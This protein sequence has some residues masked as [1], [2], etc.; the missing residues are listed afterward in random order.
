M[1]D[2]ANDSSQ[3][4]ASSFSAP[5]I[6]PESENNKTRLSDLEVS[7]PGVATSVDCPQS[8][9]AMGR[10]VLTAFHARGG[11]GEVWRCQ[12]SN[13]GR[14][15]ALKRLVG[16]HASAKERFLCEA[17]IAG[18]L[19]HPSIVPVHDLGV[20]DNGRPFYVMKFVRGR[21][22]KAAIEDF[23]A[24]V[25]PAI[26][27]HEARQIARLR[28]LKIFLDL[29]H[30]V[31]YAHSR[32]VIH[33]DIKPEIVMVGPYGETV[34]LDWGLAKLTGQTEIAALTPVSGSSCDQPALSSGNS[35]QTQDGSILGSPLYMPP[36]MA[37]GRMGDIDQRTDVYLLGATLYEILTGRPPRQGASRQEILEMART[38]PPVSPRTLASDTPRALEAICLKAMSRARERRYDGAMSVAEEIQRFLAGESVL[39]YAEPWPVRAWR[40][41]KRHR[42]PMTRAIV[43]AAFIVAVALVLI[44]YM[45]SAAGAA[46]EQARVQV[47]Q[48]RKLADQARFY[49]AGVDAPTEL[50]PYYNPGHGED[51]ARE[52][53]ATAGGWGP[54][55]D[56][57]PLV[58][59]RQPLRQELGE[60]CLLMAGNRAEPTDSRTQRTGQSNTWIDHAK[61]LGVD[62]PGSASS[63]QS[64]FLEAER[65]RLRA[66]VGA[67]PVLEDPDAKRNRTE[68]LLNA[69]E[70][71]QAA[72]V[73][74]PTLYWPHLQLGRCYLAL[75]RGPQAIE[76]LGACIALRPDAPWGYSVRGLALALMGRFDA[77]KLD[78]D[79][80]LALDPDCLAARLNRGGMYQLEGMTEQAA[81]EFDMLLALPRPSPEAAM[82]RSRIYTDESKYDQALICLDRA[83][84][85]PAQFP[86]AAYLTAKL[87]F[88]SG[89]SDRCLHQLDI[90]AGTPAQRG[91]LLRVMASELPRQQQK[92]LLELALQDLRPATESPGAPAG[93]LADL[94]AVL[95]LLDRHEEAIAAYSRAIAAAPDQAQIIIN[96]GWAFDSLNRLDEARNDFTRALQV[97]PDQAEAM[98]GLGYV[99]ARLGHAAEA[100]RQASLAVLQGGSE[101]LILHNVACIYAQL[102][103]ADPESAPAHQEAAVELLRRSIQEWRQGWYGQSEIDL[104]RQ[105]PA[106]PASMRQRK[107]FQKLIGTPQDSFSA[108]RQHV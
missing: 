106:F 31:A 90:I 8:A 68:S 12:D 20:D 97:A 93:A 52:A 96:R 92:P 60:L 77:A 66:D 3:S 23:H 48:V 95:Q 74:D 65:F 54:H 11:M 57:L 37:E 63:A 46:R 71:Y 41:A 39:A 88:L 58:E 72:I 98:T 44:Y 79:R 4:E 36:E 55:L 5:T 50:M 107:D 34:V 94:A 87:Y 32:G 81:A 105:E 33:R 6:D 24:A 47:E 26:P 53:L 67:L 49:G 70:A 22:L 21:T 64:L 75:G 76:V 2:S 69:V 100:Q 19:E 108:P 62:A 99:E 78:L 73:A 17:Q 80:A 56:G 104:I 51:L 89:D 91:R 30:A 101:Y 29:C 38:A 9:A 45:R 61:E 28:L 85:N 7:D 1:N 86:I 35:A 16:D 25:D 18:Q 40:W 10:Y 59:L 15:V 13:I 103:I 27:R 43:A 83:H 84:V 42:R 14:E 82:Y 102:S